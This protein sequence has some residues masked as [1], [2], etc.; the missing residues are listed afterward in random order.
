LQPLARPKLKLFEP[1]ITDPHQEYLKDYAEIHK[2]GIFEVIT[3]R[4]GPDIHES[5]V[6]S[7][8]GASVSNIVE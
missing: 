3:V 4:I 6:P 2:E 5:S 7:G 1:T 8:I